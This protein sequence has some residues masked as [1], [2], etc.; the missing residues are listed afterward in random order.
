VSDAIDLPL[1]GVVQ[2]AHRVIAR[3]SQ[4]SFTAKNAMFF[5]KG[6]KKKI[7]RNQIFALLAFLLCVFAV[8]F[9]FFTQPLLAGRYV[10]RKKNQLSI[11]NFQFS[12]IS[13]SLQ[14]NF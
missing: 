14:A 5:R 9:S 2:Q 12:I 4:K 3:L 6:R 1:L 11:F 13:V 7:P 8:N 10:E